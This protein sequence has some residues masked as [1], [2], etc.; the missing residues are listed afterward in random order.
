RPPRYCFI[1]H[2]R[3]GEDA[4]VEPRRVLLVEGILLLHDP[5][6]RHL[7]DLTF[8][9]DVPDDVRLAPPMRRGAPARG[10]ARHSVLAQFEATV[11]GA[12][13]RYVEPTKAVADVVLSNVA[14][15][16]RVAEVATEVIR[17]RMN[18][19]RVADA[20]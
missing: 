8:F 5:H 16:D 12:H 14:R 17:A 19:R 15:V 10:P 2:R 20:A 13:A 3:V 18:R 11:G 6:T 4:V 9:L 7:L 1:T